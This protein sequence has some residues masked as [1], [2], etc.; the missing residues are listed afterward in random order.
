MNR[1]RFHSDYI[2]HANNRA[3]VKV[4]GSEGFKDGPLYRYQDRPFIVCLCGSTKFMKDF[5]VVNEAFTLDGLIVLSV[6]VDMNNV[7]KELLPLGPQVKSR[8][9]KL[10]KRKIDL[11][12]FVY[13]VN[14]GGYVGESTKS[15]IEYAHSKGK[16]VEYLVQPSGTYGAYGG[17][18]DVLSST[19]AK[20]NMGADPG[21][22]ERDS[23]TFMFADS[24]SMEMMSKDEYNELAKIFPPPGIIVT[25]LHPMPA[26][27]SG[28]H[29][30]ARGNFVRDV[31]FDMIMNTPLVDSKI[32]RSP[33]AD[34]DEQKEKVQASFAK[35]YGLSLEDYRK[36]AP[37]CGGCGG[38]CK[39]ILAAA[40]LRKYQY[41]KDLEK[42]TPEQLDVAL[43]PDPTL[44]DGTMTVQNQNGVKRTWSKEA[45]IYLTGVFD[46]CWVF[47]GDLSTEAETWFRFPTPENL[48]LRYEVVRGL[49]TG[50][51]SEVS[52]VLGSPVK[53][54]P[55][56]PGAKMEF[57]NFSDYKE[58]NP[59]K[60]K[61]DNP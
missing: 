14:P 30:E 15:E 8:L 12:D 21:S 32:L 29:K 56:T 19:Y 46:Q 35:T 55:N 13:V 17:S 45:R 52:D 36:L 5:A 34:T 22:K 41:T 7:T 16:R 60:H 6:G 10:H 9:D 49:Q 38:E 48:K 2:P 58:K 42:M 4:T 59:A 37:D 1:R 39:R 25:E 57:G 20:M 61:A 24:G 50:V 51:Y 40:D 28:V 43:K 11:A 47:P 23:T 44:E 31:L 54:D 26:T 53:M 33:M 18:P 3:L 27:E